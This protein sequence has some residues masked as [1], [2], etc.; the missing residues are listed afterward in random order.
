MALFLEG[1]DADKQIFLDLLSNKT[2]NK[3]EADLLK[4]LTRIPKKNRMPALQHAANFFSS[5]LG[6]WEKF[7]YILEV[8]LSPENKGDPLKIATLFKNLSIEHYFISIENA[9]LLPIENAFRKEIVE[10]ALKIYHDSHEFHQKWIF[11]ILHDDFG[12]NHNKI[13][14]NI[15]NIMFQ[16]RLSREKKL[17]RLNEIKKIYPYLSEEMNGKEIGRSIQALSQTSDDGDMRDAMQSIFRLLNEKIIDISRGN[18][19]FEP[20]TM[21]SAVPVEERDNFVDLVI[22]AS[23]YLDIYFENWERRILFTYIPCFEK[24]DLVTVMLILSREERELLLDILSDATFIFDHF[25]FHLTKNFALEFSLFLTSISSNEELLQSLRSGNLKL[26]L[27]QEV[28][29]EGIISSACKRIINI[30]GISKEAITALC[31]YLF[32]NQTPFLLFEEHP[33]MLQVM[34]F[35]SLVNLHSVKNP[36]ILHKKLVDLSKQPVNFQTKP[37]KIAGYDVCMNMK[38]FEEMSLSAIIE[39]KEVPEEATLKAYDLLLSNLTEKY[40][41]SPKNFNAA[42]NDLNPD[43]SWITISQKSSLITLRGLLTLTGEQVNEVEARWRKVLANILAK[44]TEELKGNFF[45]EQEQVLLTTQYAIQACSIGIRGGIEDAYQSLPSSFK[46]KSCCFSFKTDGE[47][48]QE[49]NQKSALEFLCNWIDPDL[50]LEDLS[51]LL[52][53][54]NPKTL[55]ERLPSLIGHD[56]SFWNVTSTLESDPLDD[57]FAEWHLTPKG[58]K[59]ALHAAFKTKEQV[60][61]VLFPILSEFIE[62]IFNR[63]ND[64]VIKHFVGDIEIKQGVHQSLYIKNLIGH[65]VGLSKHISKDPHVACIYEELTNASVNEVLEVFFEKHPLNHFMKE[66]IRVINQDPINYRKSL[67]PY[68]DRP[69]FWDI[70]NNLTLQGSLELFIQSELVLIS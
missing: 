49:V 38:A 23:R 52:L 57:P 42:L 19:L 2:L 6:V 39:R 25:P 8:S 17:L 1:Q 28:Y 44:S 67:P 4:T 21:I 68:F 16:T 63:G 27:S 24:K 40:E 29:I 37:V 61:A 70:E 26:L 55:I 66:V 10:D 30:E 41:N 18:F 62:G 14:C 11:K 36:F 65:A 15:L 34:D 58:S 51:L 5:D 69:E 13:A 46:Y 60:R 43:L 35:L 45:T 9:H 20:Y 54:E 53:K 22:K 56:L 31:N 12:Q 7:T 3:T 33:T 50:N 64:A 32:K 47:L 48:L 59:A